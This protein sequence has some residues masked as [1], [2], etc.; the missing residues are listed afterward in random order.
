VSCQGFTGPTNILQGQFGFYPL[1]IHD[2]YEPD[3][4]TR[5]LG[6]HFEF[7]NTSL[8]PYP[9]CKLTHIPI[10]VTA[11]LVK[12]NGIGAEDIRRMLVHTN[13]DGY[14]KCAASPTKRRPR[15]APDAQFSLPVMLAYA[16]TR[17]GV[18][19]NDL[20]PA[21]WNEPRIQAL[22]DKVEVCIDPELEAMPVLISPAV[23]E[24]E[25]MSGKKYRERADCVVGS[26]DQPMSFQQVSE[27]FFGCTSAAVHPI[28][29]SKAAEFLQMA[30][31]LENVDDV[32]LMIKPM[33]A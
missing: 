18:T 12:E 4:I 25:M 32:R 27:K 14:V 13:V 15:N 30:S 2:N 1:Y 24:I 16:V 5:D 22:A 31:G 21:A 33:I 26:P 3:V 7:V 9:S 8:K 11:K 28:A 6:R 10:A 20:T 19:L 17:G 23:V 29:A